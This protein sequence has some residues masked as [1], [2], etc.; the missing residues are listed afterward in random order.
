MFNFP[1]TKSSQQRKTA[2]HCKTPMKRNIVSIGSY[3]CLFLLDFAQTEIA[4]WSSA[5]LLNQL[6][7]FLA[8][9]TGRN[10]STLGLLRM[11]IW[12]C[13]DNTSLL[14]KACFMLFT[15]DLWRW[16]GLLK[17]WVAAPNGVAKC[18]F[19]SRKQL[20]WQIRYNNFC[21]I[22]KTL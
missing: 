18:N 2:R 10:V 4:C 6:E 3:V 14:C 8:S 16:A 12:R 22:Y 7:Q 1:L 15:I 19:G 21:K 20:S 17:L 13:C 9:F 5:C 11:V